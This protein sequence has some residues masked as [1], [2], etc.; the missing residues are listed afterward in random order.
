MV[1][2]HGCV[3]FE[4]HVQCL[5]VSSGFVV[6][7]EAVVVQCPR[8]GRPLG[9]GRQ[10]SPQLTVGQRPLGGGGA[11]R[12]GLGGAPG[13]AVPGGGGGRF[14]GF[15]LG[16]G[17]VSGTSEQLGMRPRCDPTVRT[18]PTIEGRV[19]SAW[20]FPATLGTSGGWAPEAA[21]GLELHHA[22]RHTYIH[23][24]R[25]IYIYILQSTPL[26]QL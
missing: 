24:K 10:L 8:G 21:M 20:V 12:G 23:T 3:F 26:S 13:R 2:I 1:S 15:P 25:Y 9:P 14:P 17:A 18:A 19:S 16:G 4:P 5:A 7:V 6:N 22:T 11:W